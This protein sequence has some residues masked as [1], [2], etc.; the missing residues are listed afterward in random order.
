MKRIPQIG[1]TVVFRKRNYRYQEA[2]VLAVAYDK[3]DEVTRAKVEWRSLFG[4]R[5]HSWEWTWDLC[6]PVK[7]GEKGN[8]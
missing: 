4:F 8:G 2:I 6:Y 7:S 1:E 5:R 3:D